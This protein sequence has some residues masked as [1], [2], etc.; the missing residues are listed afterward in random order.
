PSVTV[1]TRLAGVTGALTGLAAKPTATPETGLPLA[2]RTITEGGGVTAVP[3]GADVPP[4]F[5]AIEAAAP[6]LS[7]M[8]PELT[9]VSPVPPKLSERLRAVPLS[10][11]P[12]NVA[13]PV[14]PVVAVLL[15]AVAP[16]G[17]GV[18]VTTTLL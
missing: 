16:A 12:L 18:A 17:P 3:A 13:A 2:S 4:P 14:V 7:A 6:A 9:G 1:V 5:G 11:G 8:G 15:L 10:V